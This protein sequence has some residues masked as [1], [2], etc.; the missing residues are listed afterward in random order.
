MQHLEN[1]MDEL[2]Q[3][4]A[5]HYSI[6]TGEG[7][8]EGIAGKLEA[9]QHV[10]TGG[11]VK[12][13]KNHKLIALL[14]LMMMLSVGGLLVNSPVGTSPQSK[15]SWKISMQNNIAS[16]PQELNMSPNTTRQQI[17]AVKDGTPALFIQKKVTTISLISRR[18]DDDIP[19]NI[20]NAFDEQNDGANS[21]LP[22]TYK[23]NSISTINGLIEKI[24]YQ[25]WQQNN[26]SL[27]VKESLNPSGENIT[28]GYYKPVY[29][30]NVHDQAASFP[31]KKEFYAGVVAGPDFSKITSGHF[32]NSGLTAGI[33]AGLQVGRKVA[34]ETGISW[35]R[36]NY[37]TTGDQFNMDKIKSAMPAGMVIN[38]LEGNSSLV[39]IPLKI[40]YNLLQKAHAAFFI[41]GGVTAYIM[42]NESNMYNVTM[43]GSNEKMY[44]NY[45]KNNYTLPAAAGL[46]IGYERS[47]LKN[48]NLRIEPFVTFPLQGIGVGKLPVTSAGLQFG[49]VRRI[50]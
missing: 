10:S 13:R 41:T 42:T 36:K 46:S 28:P 3:R 43:A 25:S 48:T 9:I 20:P 4:A 33:V 17:S 45:K 11:A 40:K 39:E 34:F 2:F 23:E 27:I 24:Q 47:V 30:K 49:L 29:K 6:Q 15:A 44:G 8:W 5:E 22:V 14:L 50:K 1:D 35:N 7:D 21:T 31:R 19:D 12:K 26:K 38:T 37:N 16:H 18:N 32:N